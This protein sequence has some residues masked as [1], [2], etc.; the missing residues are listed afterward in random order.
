MGINCFNDYFTLS[1]IFSITSSLLGS[2]VLPVIQFGCSVKPAIDN[3]DS[4]VSHDVDDPAF[5]SLT[6]ELPAAFRQLL[7]SPD[8]SAQVFSELAQKTFSLNFL[9]SVKMVS[10]SNWAFKCAFFNCI[11][12]F[13]LNKT[14]CTQRTFDFILEV[15]RA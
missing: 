7:S 11:D 4:V 14:K 9:K 8:H 13:A 1:F 5:D 10:Q 15:I 2:L 12:E 3:V 6:F